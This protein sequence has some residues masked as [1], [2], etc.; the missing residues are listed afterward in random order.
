MNGEKSSWK[1]FPSLVV[2]LMLFL[3]QIVVTRYFTR[4]D[5]AETHRDAM[6]L[7]LNALKV[8][9]AKVQSDLDRIEALVD[10]VSRQMNV[11]DVRHERYIAQFRMLDLLLR[12]REGKSKDTAT[13]ELGQ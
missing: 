7:E 9:Q 4:M 6:A 11:L 13:P 5:D 8:T 1:V 3:T 12:G 10:H 2:G